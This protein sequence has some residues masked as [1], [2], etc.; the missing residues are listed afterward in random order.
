V[1]KQVLKRGAQAVLE[2]EPD[3][4]G[5]GYSKYYCYLCLVFQHAIDSPFRLSVMVIVEK[6]VQAVLK[7]LLPS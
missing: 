4:T 6:H 1:L 7:V 2:S 3:L 5:M